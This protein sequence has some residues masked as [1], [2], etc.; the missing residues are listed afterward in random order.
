MIIR[1]AE[2]ADLDA[3]VAGNLA[4][5]WETETLRLDPTVLRA[6]VAFALS[7][8]QEA[9]YW[10]AVSTRS[11]EPNLL[12]TDSNQHP[13]SPEPH[14]VGQ[15]M[16]TREWSDWRNCHVWWIQSVYVWPQARKMGVWRALYAQ[17]LAEA[18]AA[19]AGVVRLYVDQRNTG[20]AAAYRQLGM[21][22]GHYQVFEQVLAPGAKA[23]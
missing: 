3:L 23:D 8:S 6:G 20:A 7:G 11:R 19:G 18:R 4:M 1:D 14:I 15:V 16:V 12:G 10:V 13:T 22:G 9:H 5:A 2:P 21:D 17:V